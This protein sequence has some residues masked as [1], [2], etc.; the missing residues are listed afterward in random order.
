MMS[1]MDP[2]L[3]EMLD[4]YEITRVLAEY[5]HGCDRVD[6]EHMASI[7]WE[8]SWDDHGHL[9]ATGPDFARQMSAQI[10]RDTDTLTHLL[11]QTLVNVEG[12]EAGAE[13]YFIAV[14][15][16]AREDGTQ[17]CNQLGGRFVDRLERREGKWKVKHRI[18]VRDWGVTIP[19]ASDW[20][21]H[22]GLFDGQ[23]SAADPSYAA[24]GLQH[25]GGPS[26]Q[27][28]RELKARVI[29]G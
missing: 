7:Y 4:H 11:G 3:Q 25:R 5:C 2:R 6:V 8:D 21:E 22:A 9:K 15:R 10:V 13:T 24:L 16:A 23:R 27:A 1:E 29:Q 20:T 19:M 26:E 28:V 17:L 12:D 14:A 18:V